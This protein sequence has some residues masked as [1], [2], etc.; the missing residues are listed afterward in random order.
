MMSES[1]EQRVENL[2]ALLVKVVEIFHKL[3]RL[4]IGE[5]LRFWMP[6]F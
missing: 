5:C 3:G 1:L 4:R 2:E 6:R